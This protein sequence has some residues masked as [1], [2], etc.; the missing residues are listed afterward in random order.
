MNAVYDFIVEKYGYNEPIFTSDL[1]KELDIN[2]NTFRQVVKRLS[3]KGLITKVE[4]GIYFIPNK[5]SVLKK[6]KLSVE[7]I[8][9]KKFLNKE[10]VIIGYKTGINF[11]NMLGLTSQTA[12]IP[13]IVTNNTA[14]NKREVAYY[15]KR[16]IVRKPKAEITAQ[17][18]KLFQVLDL[19]KDFDRYSEEP[20]E[21]A[22][23]KIID[24]LKD[25]TINENEFKKYLNSY[26]PK[27]RLKLYESGV[28]NALT[29][30]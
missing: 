19:I 29:Q 16:I 13:T 1:K 27:T 25:V 2:P 5:N 14:A 23:G 4:K 3:D 21:Q 12:S 10:N 6:P 15:N 30:R 8:I 20:L 11:A 18:Y 28:Y 22:K 9:G 17:N 7:K 24:Y 26:P